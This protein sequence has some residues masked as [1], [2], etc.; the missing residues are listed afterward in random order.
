MQVNLAENNGTRIE[1]TVN[2]TRVTIGIEV[3][4]N[5][6]LVVRQGLNTTNSEDAVSTIVDVSLINAAGNSV[7]PNSTVQICLQTNKQENKKD[8]CLGSYQ[9]A[10]GEWKCDDPCLK[11]NKNG[12]LCGD[13]DHFT[14]FAI[15]LNGNGGDGDCDHSESYITGSYD[16]DLILVIVLLLS[17]CC[18]VILVAFFS[19]F[20]PFDRIFYSPDAIKARTL[21]AHNSQKSVVVNS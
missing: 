19:S 16:G 9:E 13:V 20:K 4:T 1:S 21:R 10:T 11:S 3:R 5:V 17:C 12:L 14:N 18:L 2:G 6:T 15:L 8:L 7:Q